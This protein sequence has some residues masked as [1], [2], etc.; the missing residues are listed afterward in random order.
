M[1]FMFTLNLQYHC[2][3]NRCVQFLERKGQ[4]WDKQETPYFIMS[5]QHLVISQSGFTE[6][7][8]DL[9]T[10]EIPSPTGTIFKITTSSLS[11]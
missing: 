4:T 1:V 8:T 10:P 9:T 2:V 7:A 11:L 5:L 3:Y 6:T